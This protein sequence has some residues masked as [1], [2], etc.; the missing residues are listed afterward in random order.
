M[1]G[2]FKNMRYFSQCTLDIFSL[3][4][5]PLII[6]KEVFQKRGLSA[7]F[8]SVRRYSLGSNV[9][10]DTISYGSQ[11]INGGH[12]CEEYD[13]VP[14]FD[15]C[16][17]IYISETQSDAFL[18]KAIAYLHEYEQKPY[19]YVLSHFEDEETI[20]NFPSLEMI[21]KT[22]I[23]IRSQSHNGQSGKSTCSELSNESSIC[24]NNLIDALAIMSLCKKGGITSAKDPISWWG[25]FL[26]D[27]IRKI[28]VH[29]IKET[30]PS[31]NG[32]LIRF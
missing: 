24:D 28:I 2:Y 4:N 17:F 20:K 22:I 30:Q 1:K 23:T 10:N 32:V 13:D 27:N 3:F 9:S 11:Y 7:G 6:S 31:R 19:F 5:T 29:D 21:P 15:K 18:T 14:P 25:A 26:I 16:F 12:A 8:K